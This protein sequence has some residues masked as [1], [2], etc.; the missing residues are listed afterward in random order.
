MVSNAVRNLVSEQTI[1]YG[2]HKIPRFIYHMTNKE[3]YE[4]MLRDG[5]LK[6]R[7]DTSYGKGIFAFELGN[8]FK[9]WI[10]PC[11]TGPMIKALIERISKGSDDIVI[12]KIP[13]KKLNQNMLR[14]RSQDVMLDWSHTEQYEAATKAVKEAIINAP[15]TEG[16]DFADIAM[17][18]FKDFV[19]HSKK[20]ETLTH[21]IEGIPAK[22]SNLFKQRKHAI[23]YVYNDDIP[24]SIVE[25]IGECNMTQVE[26][27]A[28]YD[29]RKPMRSLFTALLSKT[30]EVKNAELINY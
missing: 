6:C 9:R 22:D 10:K 1:T 26:R 30:P 15:E 7:P 23:E 16:T 3:G 18:A 11:D 17:Q 5:F 27:K 28:E 8:L 14:I 19:Q 29:W 25:K 24:M 2:Q 4:S 21:I 13:T 20:D 12:L